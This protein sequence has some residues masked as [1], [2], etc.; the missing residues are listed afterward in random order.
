MDKALN[1][2]KPIVKTPLQV[3]H[4]LKVEKPELADKKMAYAGRLDPMAHGVLVVL[5]GEECKERDRY[6]DMSKVYEFEVAFG[7]STD[8]YDKLGVIKK[9]DFAK[10]I[11]LDK[12]N[13]SDLLDS[14]T[15]SYKLYYP[16]YSSKPVDGKPLFQWA[17]EGKTDQI[18]LPKKQYIV[19]DLRHLSTNEISV[20]KFI[21]QT[22]EQIE[23]VEGDF[24]QEE[25]VA[26][27]QDLLSCSGREVVITNARFIAEVGSGTYIRV[28]AHEMG[29][30]LGVP[31]LASE[32]LRIKVG[33]YNLEDSKRL[34]FL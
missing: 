30:R 2:Y 34:K 18:E 7:L 17:R 24:R 28:I 6:Q 11:G 12:E 31:A 5:V 26:K 14:F 19:R 27:W 13:L 21:E 20:E 15:G 9:Y 10:K 8:T 22:V 3:I 32:I 16:P 23:K 29:K 1:L 4:K 33:G 25:I